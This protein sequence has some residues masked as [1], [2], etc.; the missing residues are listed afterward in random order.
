MPGHIGESIH[1]SDTP[2]TP[3]PGSVQ[4]V[5]QSGGSPPPAGR[6][7][8]G[9]SARPLC[10]RPYS[11]RQRMRRCLPRKSTQSSNPP[12]TCVPACHRMDQ[13]RTAGCPLENTAI[14]L[15]PASVCIFETPP[16]VP[17]IPCKFW[18]PNAPHKSPPRCDPHRQDPYRSYSYREPHPLL[19]WNLQKSTGHC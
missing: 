5:P 13:L 2:G 6:W 10:K 15:P 12:P 3:A 9:S 18:C 7:S 14:R 17:A 16:V 8:I 1:S 4:T 11:R 19:P